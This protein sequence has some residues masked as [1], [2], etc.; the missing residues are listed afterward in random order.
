M[1]SEGA[2]FLVI[3][4]GIASAS[5][6]SALAAHGKVI[7]LE[8][9]ERPAFHSTGRSAAFYAAG[10]GNEVIRRLTAAGDGFFRNPP[11][12]FT[13]ADLLRPRDWAFIAR[14]D[15]LAHL[16]DMTE[17]LGDAVDLVQA[18]DLEQ[19]VP[20]LRKGYVAGAIVDRRGGDLDV[21]ALLQAYLRLMRQR[22]GTLVCN[23]RVEALRRSNGLWRLT[24]TVG[25]FSAPVVVNASGAWADD[26]A[27]K[28]GL[29]P[30]GLEPKRRT[31]ILVDA[32]ANMSMS[33]WPVIADIEEEF[34]FK[35]DAGRLLVSPA[36]ETPS[37]PCDAQPDEIDVAY[38]VEKLERA[39]TLSVRRVTHKWAGLRVFA[40]DR[41]P[42]A[43]FDP[44]SEG[45]FW[46]AGQGGYGVQTAPG[47]SQFVMNAIT[48][49]PTLPGFEAVRELTGA[50][51]PARFLSK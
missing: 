42:V 30:L 41:T 7:I 25:E 45:F 32:P 38:A 34:Y 33:D 40:K 10:Y 16:R 43:G 22:G 44:R 27:M 24:S 39:T 48:G 21:D 47:L 15:Q 11:D 49:A 18:N 37:P 4:A 13:S 19:A 9:E 5:A 36:D 31:A 28:A 14:A 6:A 23:A 2:D 29:E 46:L 20:V 50:L 17:T 26:V 12:A 35:P 8:A 3:G 51:S 1:A